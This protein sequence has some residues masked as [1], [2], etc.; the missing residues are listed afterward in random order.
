M[1]LS[2]SWPQ[3]KK[4][5]RQSCYQALKS[6]LVLFLVTRIRFMEPGCAHNTM[7]SNDATEFRHEIET[8][9]MGEST[10][11]HKTK[12]NKKEANCLDATGISEA[13]NI[14]IRISSNQ[15]NIPVDQTK[16]NR[17]ELCATTTTKTRERER[18]IPERSVGIL[19]F[20]LCIIRCVF[21]LSLTDFD[22]LIESKLNQ[23]Y[24]SLHCY[25]AMCIIQF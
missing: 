12:A 17:G 10:V 15:F 19:N 23:T 20:M 25:I 22:F 3:N 7:A 6:H 11:A 2:L 9:A 4:Q 5:L 18:E 21:F 8:N 16:A 13:A 1:S 24:C 14:S